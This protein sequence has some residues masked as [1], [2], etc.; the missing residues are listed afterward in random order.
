MYQP[1][2]SYLPGLSEELLR[3]GPLHILSIWSD[4]CL[5]LLMRR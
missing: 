4:M 5:L 1:Y 2:S 3:I